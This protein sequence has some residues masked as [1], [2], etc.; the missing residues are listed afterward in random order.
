MAGPD[1]CSGGPW[2]GSAEVIHATLYLD[3][4]DVPVAG[5][6]E[7]EV[8]AQY[9]EFQHPVWLDEPETEEIVK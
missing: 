7:A 6:S 9:H 4:H 1:V 3:R 5:L 2:Q 8:L